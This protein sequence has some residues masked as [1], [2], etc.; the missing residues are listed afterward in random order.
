MQLNITVWIVGFLQKF[1][2]FAKFGLRHVFVSFWVAA[3]VIWDQ[4][5]NENRVSKGFYAVDVIVVGSRY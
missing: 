5:I 4:N 2:F 1:D 3:L